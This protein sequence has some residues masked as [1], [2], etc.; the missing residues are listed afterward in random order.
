MVA[1]AP[2]L[3]SNIVEVPGQEPGRGN[4][5]VILC[6][7]RNYREPQ[8]VPKPMGDHRL[9]R[10][11]GCPFVFRQ[12]APLGSDSVTFINE[13]HLKLVSNHSIVIGQRPISGVDSE[14]GS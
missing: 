14:L 11:M 12:G 13:S 1:E 10:H 9:K 3:P 5:S 4:H 7:I 2:M 8:L 6:P